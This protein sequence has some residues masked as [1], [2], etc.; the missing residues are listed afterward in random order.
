[1][2]TS[3]SVEKACSEVGEYSDE[4]MVD[5]FDRFFREQPAICEFVVELTH[6]SGQKIQELSLF[7][8]YMVFKA[9][10]MNEPGALVP[11]TSQAIET[12]Y[13]DSESWIERISAA[14]SE[15]LQSTIAA[16]LQKDTEPYLLQYVISEL[17]APLDDG[18]ALDDEEKGEVFFVL[19]TVISSLTPEE[20][21]KI[22]EIE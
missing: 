22:I 1:M 11:V 3:D 6:E 18:S 12:A 21:G 14:E 19:K 5:E 13:R 20:K 8:A 9:I 10:E 2:I 17:N 15:E 16:S 4:K 7:L